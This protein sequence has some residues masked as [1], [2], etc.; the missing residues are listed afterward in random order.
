MTVT[1][2]D[3]AVIPVMANELTPLKNC[4]IVP[5]NCVPRFCRISGVSESPMSCSQVFAESSPLR[6]DSTSPDQD[7][8]SSTMMNQMSET[9][10]AAYTVTTR[11]AASPPGRNRRSRLTT[12]HSSA[13]CANPRKAATATTST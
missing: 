2:V 6:K 5:R 7:R 8:D 11:I 3:T 4:E 12:G 10:A 9:M 1:S 13:V